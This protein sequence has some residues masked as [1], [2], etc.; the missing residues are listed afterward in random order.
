M[1]QQGFIEVESTR[2]E[3]HCIAGRRD[4][5]VLVL[6]HEGLGSVSM[7]K[8]FPQRLAE[9][10]G[11]SVFCYSRQGY[12]LSDPCKFPRDVAYM[13]TEAETLER[14]LAQ[15]PGESF[16]LV[17]H[18]DGASIATI[19]TGSNPKAFVQGQVLI[20]PHF[21]VET[22]T[23]E[24]IAAAKLLYETT[25]LKDRLEKYHLGQVDETFWGW[26]DVW[27]SSA[28]RSWN[29]TEYLPNIAIPTLVI[30]GASDEYGSV[31]QVTTAEQGINGPVQTCLLPDCGHS[32][33][34]QF[35]AAAVSAI[36]GFIETG[37]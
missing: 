19:Y 12:G 15:I 3:Y 21:F 24:S 4:A 32:P 22:K 2:L 28:F 18:S 23:I 36:A 14:L 16:I 37:L 11:L 31:A 29:I 1:H 9:E 27:L 35:E 13:H 5:P 8:S 30:Q 25:D 34:R 26:N 20:A 33:H 10:T 7:W 17:G 6:L